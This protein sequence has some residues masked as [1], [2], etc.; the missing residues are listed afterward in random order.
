ML[1]RV[2]GQQVFI[3]NLGQSRVNLRQ[4]GGINKSDCAI[5]LEIPTS[6]QRTRDD[7]EV[8]WTNSVTSCIKT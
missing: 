8:P 1:F 2:M 3:V 4:P 7:S 5:M 6:N